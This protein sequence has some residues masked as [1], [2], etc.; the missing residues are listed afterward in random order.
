MSGNDDPARFEQVDWDAVERSRW[1]LPPERK[2]L[3]IGVLVVAALFL[4]DSRVR[5][6]YWIVGW[7]VDRIDWVFLLGTVVLVSYVAVPAVRRRESTRRVLSHLR[8]RPATA[9]AGAYL[10]AFTLVG[11]LGPAILGTPDI[12]F[13]HGIH[14]P[15]G[16]SVTSSIEPLNY[17]GEVT[18]GP[19]DSR[20]HGSWQYPLGTNLRGHPMGHLVVSGAR[21]ALYVVV[22]TAAFVVPLAAVVGVAAGLRGGRLDDALMAYVDAQLCLPA[23]VLYLVGYMYW[24]TSLLLLLATF[25]LL[26]WGGIARLV[27]SEVLQRR[28]DGYVLVA[29]SLGA[30][31]AY[32]AKRHILPNVTNTLVPAVFQLL[33]LLVLVEAG[34]AFL[35]FHDVQLYSWGSTISESVNAAVASP[36]QDRA[37]VP[38]YRIWWVSTLPALALTATLLS[39]KLVGDG[40]R[41]ALDPHGGER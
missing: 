36:L 29:R 11:L 20:C 18:G 4:Y 23:M 25:G 12:R 28:E 22:F 39:F 35:G 27:R 14:P 31:R 7:S 37:S 19:F 40:L 15:V 34:V 8:A 30:S 1:N 26:S 6:L 17:V 33:A 3:L 5:S 9:L 38:A 13:D 10:T 2:A 32:I 21:V 41:D 16:F 24:N